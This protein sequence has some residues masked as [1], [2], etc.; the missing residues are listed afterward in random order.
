MTHFAIIFL[1]N[2]LLQLFLL[3]DRYRIITTVSISATVFITSMLLTLPISKLGYSFESHEMICILINVALLFTS[4]LYLFKNSIAQKMYICVLCLSNH[5]F[6]HFL[7]ESFM[8]IL[9]IKSAGAFS[10]FFSGSIT[11]L[12]Y[13]LTGMCLYRVVHYFF[14]RTS[15]SFMIVMIFVQLTPCLFLGEIFDSVF[16]PYLLGSKLILCLLV[17]TFIIFSFR[18]LYHAAKFREEL[19]M[20]TAKKQLI[21]NQA[22]R[23]VETYALTHEHQRIYREQEYILDAV[24]LMVKD[25]VSDQ[26]PAFI[27]NQRQMRPESILMKTFHKNPYL[28]SVLLSHAAS[29]KEN[30]INFECNVQTGDKR[31]PISELC[32]LT[33]EILSKACQEARGY[34]PNPRVRYSISPSRETLRIEAVFSADI[35]S[36]KADKNR[37]QGYLTFSS[38]FNRIFKEATRATDS[39]GLEHAKELV[40]KYS[41]T[42][43]VSNTEDSVMIHI[44]LHS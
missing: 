27:H 25:S 5:Y 28:N 2:C 33:N 16:S 36:R 26:I 10:T 6:S 12:F 34:S 35:Y 7:S 24:T 40:A 14:D 19:T 17:Y 8:S 41:G 9:P 29:A 15:S 13:L 39:I 31:F 1:C 23:F 38:I 20:E 3:E 11:L 21:Q 4:S 22:D 42:M 43:D 30:H 18:S 44:S 37:S 32:V